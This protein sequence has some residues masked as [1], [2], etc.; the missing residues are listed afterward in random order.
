M[1]LDLRSGEEY[2][3]GGKIIPP[4]STIFDL[5]GS[6]NVSLSSSQELCPLVCTVPDAS[7]MLDCSYVSEGSSKASGAP[8]FL[9]APSACLRGLA[10]IRVIFLSLQP[11]AWG[12]RGKCSGDRVDVTRGA[13]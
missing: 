11:R 10:Q 12:C 7:L 4:F 13:S 1:V 5:R 6:S 8:F 3:E 9:T 2:N